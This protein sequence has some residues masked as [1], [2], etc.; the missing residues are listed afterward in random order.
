MKF[1]T[2]LLLLAAMAGS[3]ARAQTS[4]NWLEAAPLASEARLLA[5]DRQPDAVRSLMLDVVDTGKRL[6]AVGERGHILASVDGRRW[7]Q[8]EVPVRSALTAVHFIDERRGWAVGHDAV[9]LM[10]ADGGRS[11]TLQQ[12]RPEL[13]K[14]LLDVLFLDERR[15]YAVGAF[16]LFLASEDGGTTWTERRLAAVGAAEPNLHSLTRLGN[17][18]LLLTGERGLLLLSTDQGRSWTKLNSPVGVTVFGAAAWSASGVLICGLRGQAWVSRRPRV[19]GWHRIDTGTQ[20]GLYGCAAIDPGHAAMV[21]HD[22]TIL[23]ADLARREVRGYRSPSPST[24]SAVA[25]W[26]A[27]L[28]LAGQAGLRALGPV[29]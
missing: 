26:Q 14:P 28:V 4:E 7:L 29:R 25:R 16:G 2:A 12:F 13:E 17:G 3:A 1:V 11:W 22:G 27:N 8:V 19:G 10:T 23:V 21:G 9:I 20:A 15:G 5:A 6:I 18:D 24:W